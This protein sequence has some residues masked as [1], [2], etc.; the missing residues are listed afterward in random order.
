[1]N[2]NNYKKDKCAL[3]YI[4]NI[5]LSCTH[6]SIMLH[7]WLRSTNCTMP[8]SRDSHNS[9]IAPAKQTSSNCVVF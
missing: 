6:I 1:M 7:I 4:D 2:E 9:L 5:M 8:L 3:F